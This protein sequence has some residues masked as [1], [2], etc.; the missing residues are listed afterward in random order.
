MTDK[1]ASWLLHR[2]DGGTPAPHPALA[3]FRDGVLSRAAV[4]PGDVVLDVGTGTGLIGFGA[5][6]LVGVD[7]KVIFSDVSAP[8]L[9]ECRRQAGD[10]P[11]CSFVIASADDLT[12]VPDASVDVVTTRSVLMYVA[13]RSRA[14]GEL[15]R[16]LRPGGRLSI[17][18]PINRFAHGRWGFLGLDLSA[19]LPLV[20][21]VLAAYEGE[22]V[23]IDFDERDLLAW[24]AEAGFTA[25]ELDYRA[26]LDVPAD[27]LPGDWPALR[28]TAPNPLAP[29]YREAM[30]ATLTDAEREYLEETITGLLEAGA[31]RRNTGATA[32]MR[33]VRA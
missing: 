6:S 17:F 33:A 5:L 3:A 7:G 2:R 28:E 15:A 9:A 31:P 30:E 22:E 4:E 24:G 16:V 12:E 23:I 14:F 32:Y 29:T 13:D 25:L 21:K 10:D 19:V 1:W 8:L 20:T 18:E 27:P 26:T 11:R